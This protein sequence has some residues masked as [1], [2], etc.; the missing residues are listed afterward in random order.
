[1]ENGSLDGLYALG[2]RLDGDGVISAGLKI[3]EREV[4]VLDEDGAAVA[5]KRLQVVVRHLEEIRKRGYEGLDKWLRRQAS[6]L[7]AHGSNPAMTWLKI[8]S[9]LS[10]P[11]RH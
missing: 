6:V 1:M 3:G 9:L 8:T 2:D 5:V 4:G 11:Y 10:L 7:E